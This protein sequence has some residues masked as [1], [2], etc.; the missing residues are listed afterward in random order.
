MKID[1]KWVVT[2]YLSTLLLKMYRYILQFSY[3][4]IQLLYIVLNW[5]SNLNSTLS[6]VHRCSELNFV[7]VTFPLDKST[8]MIATTL[9]FN[10]PITVAM[11]LQVFLYGFSYF[12]FLHNVFRAFFVVDVLKASTVWPRSSYITNFNNRTSYW[13]I[14]AVVHEALIISP[15]R[16]SSKRKCGGGKKE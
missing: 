11:F 1:S 9:W 5:F 4:T 6:N 13:H 7:Q 2:I 12:S 15:V 3:F 16:F 10:C 14:I 8:Q